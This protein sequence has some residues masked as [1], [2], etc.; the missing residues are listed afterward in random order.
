MA[1]EVA[2]R[3][4]DPD[5]RAAVLHSPGHPVRGERVG[6]EP[7]QRLTL[8]TVGAANTAIGAVCSS[9]P[10][11]RTAP[12]DARQ[13]RRRRGKR[14]RPVE[15]IDQGLVQV[16][17]PE[18]KK[19]GSEGLKHTKVASSLRR[20]HTC[21]TTDRN[22]AAASAAASPDIGLKLNSS[23]SG[24]PLVLHR[25]RQQPHPV[26]GVTH[27]LQ[28]VAH[29]VQPHLGQVL[30]APLERGD[31]RRRWRVNPAS[32][33]QQR[34]PRGGHDVEL[35]LDPGQESRTPRV[36][37]RGQHPPEQP[38]PV[39]RHRLPVAEVHVAQHPAGAV[40]PGQDAEGS[41]VEAPASRQGIR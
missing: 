36:T 23:R 32:L 15:P 30:V 11:T 16:L 25:P 34:P 14:V 19:F 9:S 10:A 39:Q 21:L 31:R 28:R 8:L 5:Q 20:W 33:R 4:L 13:R 1:A 27:R 37:Q 41:R 17:Y 3:A 7:P 38:A 22:S 35:D 29:A 2:G 26:Q 12:P 18:E 6:P 24:S 40:G